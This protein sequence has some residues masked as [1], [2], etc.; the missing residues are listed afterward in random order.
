MGFFTWFDRWNLRKWLR[1]QPAFGRGASKRRKH[2]FSVILE[3]VD[4]LPPLAY[5]EPTETV[6]QP[7]RFARHLIDKRRHCLDLGHLKRPF[8]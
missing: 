2:Q 6:A 5:L 1:S 8:N 3:T 4:A 7:P